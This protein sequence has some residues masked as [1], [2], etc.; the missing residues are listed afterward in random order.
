MPRRRRPPMISIEP[1]AM[2]LPLTEARILL[3]AG[4]V[5]DTTLLYGG[6]I[7][8]AYLCAGEFA[9]GLEREMLKHTAQEPI[10]TPTGEA[11]AGEEAGQ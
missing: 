3:A 7:S 9:K 4:W 10:A 5:K 8:T 6:S 11:Q 1:V 2:A